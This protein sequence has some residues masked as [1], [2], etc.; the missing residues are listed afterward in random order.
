[1]WLLEEQTVL[2]TSE[3]SLQPQHSCFVPGQVFDS[4]FTSEDQ[5]AVGTGTEKVSQ[6]T[7]CFN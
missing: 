5:E 7:K 2:L 3:P 4:Y 1:M 6:T